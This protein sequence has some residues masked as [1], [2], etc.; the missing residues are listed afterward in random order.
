MTE[1]ELVLQWT[2]WTL[3][4]SLL[5]F[6]VTLAISWE[7]MRRWQFRPKM[8]AL[9]L[10]R[11]A[12][13]GGALLLLNQPEWVERYRPD[14]KPAIVL[15]ADTSASME[16]RDV[17]GGCSSRWNEFPGADSSGSALALDRPNGLGFAP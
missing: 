5:C 17:V 7:A 11:L 4:F 10:L 16:T 1:R 9:E 12:L 8:V 14:Q 3:A 13:V 6:L 2:P 15:L